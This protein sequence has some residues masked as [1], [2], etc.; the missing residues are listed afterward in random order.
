MALYESLEQLVGAA[1]LACAPA[2]GCPIEARWIREGARFALHLRQRTEGQATGDVLDALA[3]DVWL[4]QDSRG[5]PHTVSEAHAVALVDV[6]AR[7]PPRPQDVA[8]GIE[9]ARAGFAGPSDGGVPA[10]RRIA[11]DV[12]ARAEALGAAVDG[13]G[14]PLDEAVS[15][16]LLDRLLAHLL[17]DPGLLASLAAVVRE[18]TGI[19]TPSLPVA[20]TAPASA[21]NPT[22]PVT[23]AARALS[24]HS[25]GDDS[26]R[27]SRPGGHS[28]GGHSVVGR[29][30]S[31]H[32]GVGI[33]PAARPA[34]GALSELSQP[35]PPRPG[36][37]ALPAASSKTS[38]ASPSSQPLPPAPRAAEAAGTGTGASLDA[39]LSALVARGEAE[40]LEELAAR[41]Q[42]GRPSLERALSVLVAE[43]VP[44]EHV[45]ARLEDLLAWV[46]GLKEALGRPANDDAELRRLKQRALAALAE[47]D[48]DLAGDL[49][50]QMRRR[51]RE[52]RR[53]VEERLEEEVANLRA[54]MVE[55]AQATARLAELAMARFDFETA[56]DLFAEAA[57]C[58][59]HN[60]RG[61]QWR[62]AM[63]QAEAHL[64]RGEQRGDARAFTRAFTAYEGAATLASEAGNPSGEG[65]ACAG[66]GQAQLGLGR[67]AAASG[68]A[69]TASARLEEAVA[70]FRKALL[71]MP[72]SEEPR[73]WGAT[74][75]A[76]GQALEALYEREGRSSLLRDAA[77]AYRE[78]LKE[79]SRRHTPLEWARCQA[80]LGAVLLALDERE[81]GTPALL[82]EAVEAFRHALEVL[83]R[84]RAEHE[85]PTLQ[86]SL[87]NALLG[88]G[89]EEGGSSR[90]EEAVAA[91][92]EAL[93]GLTR[94]VNPREWSLLQMHLGNALAALGDRDEAATSR[95]EEAVEA[96]EA[97]L[98]ELSR[99]TAALAWAITQMNL[100]TVLIRLG[101]RK[102]K[103]RHWLAAAAAMVPALEVFER[104]GA[105]EYAEL[106]R[107]NLRRFHEQWAAILEPG[108]GPSTEAS[109]A[110]VPL[111]VRRR[112]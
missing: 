49:M 20:S 5:I 57:E 107:R 83:T 23:G 86:T 45:L 27:E 108:P 13:R 54:Q 78:G 81:G 38:A 50:R 68:E 28:A 88:L 11:A 67:L 4:A 103:R 36:E 53:R 9:K 65:I 106:T 35:A 110:S 92:R 32:S 71:A 7:V 95:F 2:V 42:L 87:G 73:R 6:L 69:R 61:A 17:D 40:A 76:L 90:L 104:E 37:G 79:L 58:A 44:V 111:D 99:E 8:A 59:P 15:I 41:H 12:V 64:R 55:E 39:L 77:A 66:L 16:F 56:A 75:L 60:D 105:A 112:M 48:L 19:P 70:S 94:D 26:R 82:A 18:F 96:Y 33:S 91:F 85:W 47:M 24:P 74:Q 80:G 101:E 14:S 21:S 29:A 97:S 84:E 98:S 109:T 31:G 89:T 46:A 30:G 52:G 63:R 25:A 102:E 34:G 1:V 62:F 51:V 3:R 22:Q 72:R 10:H 93:R 43:Q 100:G